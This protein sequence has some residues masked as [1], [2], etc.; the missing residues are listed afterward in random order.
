[1]L[2]SLPCLL[3]R[4][5]RQGFFGRHVVARLSALA[6]YE[7]DAIAVESCGSA[8]HTPLPE[9][10]KATHYQVHVFHG[11]SGFLMTKWRA[12]FLDWIS[13]LW[14]LLMLQE[15]TRSRSHL[16]FVHSRCRRSRQR[17]FCLS[18]AVLR[19]SKHCVTCFDPSWS[20]LL[21]PCTG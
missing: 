2:Y 17:G 3:K 18:Q 19:C 6:R 16:S 14:S 13:W 8:L 1:M 21:S 20:L 12:V 5:N 4:R 15:A 7:K 9:S 10:S 11:F